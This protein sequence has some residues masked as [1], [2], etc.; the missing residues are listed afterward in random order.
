MLK[1]VWNVLKENPTWILLGFA[2][3]FA[4]VNLLLLGGSFQK[5]RLTQRLADQVAALD[6]NVKLLQ[7]AEREG[8]QE[9][10]DELSAAEIYLVSLQEMFPDIETPFDLY[11][12]GYSLASTSDVDLTSIYRLAS[13]T[14]S[15]IL[16]SLEVTN[17]SVVSVAE[18]ESCLEYLSRLEDEGSET[19]ALNNISIEPGLEVCS[20]EV[21]IAGIMLLEAE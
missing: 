17:Y 11:R 12:R 7:E 16:G 9:L 13:E 2:I 1:K 4:G 19:L 5:E 21:R 6:A 15:T 3:I 18:L 20:F 14:Q 10:E 8:L